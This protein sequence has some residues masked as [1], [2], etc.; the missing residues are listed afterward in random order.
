MGPPLIVPV[1]SPLLLPFLSPLLFQ[2]AARE[3]LPRGAL[4]AAFE[5]NWRGGRLVDPRDSVAV[6]Y[7][8]LAR[9]EYDNGAHV[10]YYTYC[11]DGGGAAHPL[12]RDAGDEKVTEAKEAGPAARAA[13]RTQP[14][15]TQGEAAGR[16]GQDDGA[17]LGRAVDRDA[18]MEEQEAV[19]RGGQAVR[20]VA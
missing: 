12:S 18:V 2:S 17:C 20:A 1:L 16:S 3:A 4:K 13:G 8:A 14:E 10:D 19:R 5:A 7:D 9:D 11:A 15:S 6:L